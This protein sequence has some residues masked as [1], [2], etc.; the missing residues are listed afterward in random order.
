M[1]NR[2][3]KFELKGVSDEG[4]F[5]G[6]ASVFGNVDLGFDVVEPGAFTR[7][8]AH[9]GGEVPILFAH[10]TRQPIGLGKLQETAKGLEIT[11]EL[12]MET[13]K[14]KEVFALMKKGVLRGLSIGYDVVKDTIANGVRHL[15][16][17]KLYEVSVVTFPMNEL[18]TVT[19]VKTEDIEAGQ[20]QAFRETLAF[21]TKSF[22]R[23]H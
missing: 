9:K 2:A 5:T 6:L 20:I 12:V 17:L 15:Q 3:F 22:A 18:A 1:Q 8:L 23:D 11:G 16:E 10:D 19:S 13:A 21:C 7:T 14:G 4:V